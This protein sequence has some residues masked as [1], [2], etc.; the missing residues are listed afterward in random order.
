[1]AR[2]SVTVQWQEIVEADN[3]GDALIQADMNFSMM[4]DARVEEIEEPEAWRIQ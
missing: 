3:E 4:D 2:W 1:M